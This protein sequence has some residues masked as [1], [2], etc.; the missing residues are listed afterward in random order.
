M[1]DPRKKIGE[2]R[3][4][5]NLTLSQL[6]REHG[7]SDTSV[8]NWYNEKN[9]MPTIKVLEDVCALFK[10]DM[11]E[12]FTDVQCDKLDARQ[13]RLLELFQKLTER[14]KDGVLAIIEDIAALNKTE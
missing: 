10:V 4:K 12:L 1:V 2:L 3:I 9:S 11:V 8:Y 6:A 5:N 13:I 14:Q 7:L